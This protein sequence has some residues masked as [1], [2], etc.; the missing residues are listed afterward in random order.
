MFGNLEHLRTPLTFLC[1]SF[2]ILNGFIIVINEDA[3]FVYVADVAE[4][5]LGVKSV[6]GISNFNSLVSAVY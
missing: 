4:K 5:I 3:K 6:S 1:T 2:Q